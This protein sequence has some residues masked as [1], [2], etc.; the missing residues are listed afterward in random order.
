MIVNR[1]PYCGHA[2]K[3]NLDQNAK[4]WALL[5]EIADQLRPQG[6]QYS[7]DTWHE[8]FKQ[9]YLGAD[10]VRLPNGKVVSRS[11]ST[12]D[13]D[14]DEMSVYITKIEAWATEKGVNHE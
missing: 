12:S 8:Y 7:A 14:K 2:P 11:R 13:L 9:R 6:Q 10:E 3:R 5:H 4:Y 1:C